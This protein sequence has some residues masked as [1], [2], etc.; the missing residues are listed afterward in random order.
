M[1]IEGKPGNPT[2][3]IMFTPHYSSSCRKA[4]NDLIYFNNIYINY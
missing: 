3:L 4:L 1:V 2:K